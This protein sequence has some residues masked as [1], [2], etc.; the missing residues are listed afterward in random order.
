MT[1]TVSSALP[2][3]IAEMAPGFELAAALAPV[4]VRKLS[5]R[6]A[7]TVMLA[8][9]RQVSH[10]KAHL[11]EAI[12]EAGL[13]LDADTPERAPA[14]DGFAAEESRAALV[15]SRRA[16]R[17]QFRLA[18]D[19][20]R[21]IP[22]VFLA[23][24]SGR[25]DESRARAFSEGTQDVHPDIVAQV[26]GLL[27][28]TA[29]QMLLGEL[30]A[31]IQEIVLALDPDWAR[32]RE[33]R[34]ESDRR[35]IAGKNRSGTGHL[36]GHD[37]PLDRVVL[38][39]GRIEALA[40]TAKARG[41]RA[42]ID[43][44]RA[45]LF[46]GLLDG[47]Y[48][49]LSDEEIVETFVGSHGTEAGRSTPRDENEDPGGNPGDEDPGSGGGRPDPDPSPD[50][51]PSDG[52]GGAGPDRS[53][54]GEAEPQPDARHRP[55]VPAPRDPASSPTIPVIPAAAALTVPGGR[56]TTPVT[57]SAAVTASLVVLPERRS[58]R[59]AP[60]CVETG[61]PPPEARR[62]DRRR[63]EMRGRLTTLLG[64]DELPGEL[65]GWGPILADRLRRLASAHVAAEW[66]WV[67]TDPDG[68]AIAAGLLPRR[69]RRVAPPATGASA[70]WIDVEIAVPA[71]VLETIDPERHPTWSRMLAFLRA[72]R[73][74]PVPAEGSTPTTS[75]G[76][77]PAPAA[78]FADAAL[79]RAV[80]IRDRQCVGVACRA[81]SF[82][83]EI[84]HTHD[85]ALGGATEA[86]NLGC[87]CPACHDL[88]S[89]SSWTLTQ[90]A[91]GHFVW[92][93]PAGADYETAPIPV[94]RSLPAPRPPRDGR[95]RGTS[96][97][98]ISH[99]TDQGDRSG[100]LSSMWE[101][102]AHP[103]DP[104]GRRYPV[105]RPT[106]I[107]YAGPPPF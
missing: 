45:D 99:P 49:G 68:R 3:G 10:E 44:V 102:S 72:Q 41:L 36:S 85:H 71:H 35:V 93:S 29:G 51:G 97:P 22:H 74:D 61:T 88:K 87:L 21:R 34:S 66:R 8:R 96:G 12:R 19:L 107:D 81:P 65:C 23:M 63:G 70:A 11:L 58:P 46:T 60:S 31:R 17:R 84:D 54:P 76:T 55:Y 92:H 83:A 103:K 40:A 18:D 59:P 14:D 75:R 89:R 104:D 62:L 9:A 15:L 105:P 20:V 43:Q 79:E 16:A 100:G 106:S 30:M 26:M 7:V 69:C 86:H 98:D 94:I 1:E 24:R 101:H 64:L 78:R 28:P 27:L 25:I 5:G 50:G 48:A 80:R 56:L 77:P 6:D 90:T 47:V 4:E 42:P 39:A 38:A 91:P 32:R 37:L 82:R 53:D 52:A 13:A 95:P 67:I 57:A 73:V 2:P 33:E